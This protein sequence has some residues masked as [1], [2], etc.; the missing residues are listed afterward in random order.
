MK[1]RLS[2]AKACTDLFYKIGASR[3]KDII[4]EFVSAYVENRE[5]A[6]RIAQWVRDIRGGSGERQLFKNILSY[7]DQNDTEAC[8]ILQGKIPELGRWDDLLIDYVSPMAERNA[9]TIINDALMS[10]NGLCAKWMPRKGVWANKVR[11][12]MGFTP[13]EYR[14]CV[15]KLTN[16]VET[17]MCEK[18]W[19]NINFS[20]VPSLAAARYKKAFYRNTDKYAEYVDLLTSGDKSVKVNASAVY[21]YDVIKGAFKM[22]SR[23][24]SKPSK[25]ELDLMNAQWDALPNY[26]NDANVFPM[27][28]VSGSM[29]C[30]V[31]GNAN[32]TCI[33]V[34]VSLGLYMADKNT[35]AFKDCFLTFSGDPQIQKVKG[36]IVQKIEQ[37]INAHWSMNTNLHAAFDR[38]LEVGKSNGVS[39]EDMP[40]MILIFSDMQFDHCVQFDD[41]AIQ[42]IRRKYESAGYD[43]PEIVFWNINAYGNVPVK[44]NE[45][46]VALVSGFS[47][48]IAKSLLEAD[49][50]NF[51]PESI[52]LQ[53]ILNPRYDI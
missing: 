3:G 46:G 41:S 36:T 51:T 1:A 11:K 38:V 31:G 13:K 4:P 22:F 10:E 44:F 16:V 23:W 50:D 18:D 33:D 35:G 14:K 42:M 17:Q 37:T 48:A 53:T 9:L 28:D 20:H 39:N 25:T 49:M 43:V 52:M 47:P 2:S 12:F 26:V 19:D 8:M 7:L 40:K 15:V 5:Y 30:P 45:K 24:G 21:P 32:L 27:I 34:A 29:D 6:L